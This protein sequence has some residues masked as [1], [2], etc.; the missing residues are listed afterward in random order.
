MNVRF[1]PLWIALFCACGCTEEKTET[2]LPPE[3]SVPDVRPAGGETLRG[4]V[5]VKFKSAVGEVEPTKTKSGGIVTGMADVDERIAGMRVA[6]M[7]RVFPHAGRFEERTRR[8]GLHLW[9]DVE[10]DEEVPVSRAV[11]EWQGLPDVEIVEPVFVIEGARGTA[12]AVDAPARTASSA[13]DMPFDDPLLPDQWHYHNTGSLPNSVSGADIGLFDAWRITRGSREVIVAVVDGGIDYEHE[14]LAGNVGNEAELNGLPGVDD[15]GNGFV[16]DYYGWNFVENHNRIETDDHGTH[17]AGT[18]AAENGNGTGVC[19]VA[20]GSGGHT[21]VRVISC[22]I[23]GTRNGRDVSG[24]SPEAIKYAADAGAVICQNSWGYTDAVYMPEVTRQAIDYFVKYAGT[25]EYGEQVGPMKGGI[26]IFAA[27]NEN[28]DYRC[29]PAA[30]DGVLSVS[31]IAPDYCKSWYSN[32][33]SW[34]DVAAPGGTFS[35][36]TKYS[37]QCAVLS[38][39]RNGRYGYLQGTSM[40]CPHVSGVAALIVSK[41]GGPG[42]TP[43]RVWTR[44]VNGVRD[45]DAFNPQYAGRL[46]SGCV[47]ALMALSD[48]RGIAPDPVADVTFGATAGK[49]RATWKVTAD[50]DDGTASRYLLYWDTR[51]FDGL[52]P[53]RLPEGTASAVVAVGRDAQPGDTISYVMEEMAENTRYYFAILASDPWGNLSA[54]STFSF[55][56]PY[57]RPPVIVREGDDSVSLAYNETRDIVFLVSDPDGFD[58]ICEMED[59]SGSAALRQDGDRAVVTFRNYRCKA[60]KYTLRLT[61][62][63]AGGATAVA[64]LPFELRENL[65]P[66]LR[67][68]FENV[69]LG[70]LQEKFTVSLPSCFSDEGP[71]V[72]VYSFE[73]DR[74]ALSLV[75]RGNN[76]EIGALEYGLSEVTVTATDG[77]GLSASASFLVMARDYT[78]PLDLYPN[79]VRDYLNIRMGRDKEGT[80]R[81]RVFDTGGRQLREQSLAIG[82]F[83]PARL[84]LSSLSGGTYRVS[85]EYGGET[86]SGTIVKL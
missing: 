54:A 51:P 20:G 70:S 55:D 73:Y 16:D 56:T 12:V 67:A 76:L 64:E 72:L 21:G 27:G 50:E 13:G 38:T 53:D 74:Q 40:A 34:I 2:P 82:P 66:V 77:E 69:Y 63:D 42:F 83:A 15:D 60:G 3:D 19:G 85:V 46:G 62:T 33:A 24:G 52:A 37:D 65:P 39:L 31:A 17:V 4:R 28:K 36:G 1:I 41:L 23:F 81:V 79:P 57:N 26:V 86:Y 11:S 7:E 6:S 25:D 68:P 71:A 43:D 75:Q 9:Y 5:R 44:L 58:C 78:Q 29:Y 45:V 48:N 49:V 22:Q 35:R 61:A 59:P 14:D 32:Y 18:I 10:F 84:D 8:E 80:I 30:Y 47:D